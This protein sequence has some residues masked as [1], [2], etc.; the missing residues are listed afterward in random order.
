MY[1]S[2]DYFQVF[3]NIGKTIMCKV[4]QVH[5]NVNGNNIYWDCKDWQNIYEGF[6]RGHNREGVGKLCS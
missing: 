2:K 1:N 6:Q 4:C 3:I 5:L